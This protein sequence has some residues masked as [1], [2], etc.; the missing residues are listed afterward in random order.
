M[1]SSS[2]LWQLF[3]PWKSIAFCVIKKEFPMRTRMLWACLHNQQSRKE[4]IFQFF[5]AFESLL[6]CGAE[7]A[8]INAE[9]KRIY[10][11]MRK[12]AHKTCACLSLI[13]PFMQFVFEPEKKLSF[14]FLLDC[15]FSV[16]GSSL[17]GKVCLWYRKIPF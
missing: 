6:I 14:L 11:V 1:P 3:F 5:S 8:R 12:N 4:K 17:R 16:A 15:Q 9:A 7:A 10:C 2:W 13:V